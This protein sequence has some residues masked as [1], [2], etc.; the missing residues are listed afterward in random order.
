MLLFRRALDED[1]CSPELD[2]R[3]RPVLSFGVLAIVDCLSST[4]WL[5][6]QG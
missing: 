1:E 3:F 2:R 4:L 6:A 5:L